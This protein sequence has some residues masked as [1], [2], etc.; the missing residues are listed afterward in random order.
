MND[1]TGTPSPRIG[2]RVNVT[3]WFAEDG[4]QT[5]HNDEQATGVEAFEYAWQACEDGEQ[6]GDKVVAVVWQTE[7]GHEE[8]RLGERRTQ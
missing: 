2:Y 4:K 1:M 5:W 3:R 8:T 6:V 7:D